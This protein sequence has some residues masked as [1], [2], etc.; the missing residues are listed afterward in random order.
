[1]EHRSLD[2]GTTPEDDIVM[3]YGAFIIADARCKGT[4]VRTC[5]ANLYPISQQSWLVIPVSFR[6][7]AV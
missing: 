6:A 1:M 7:L 4:A 3:T 5:R 2:T